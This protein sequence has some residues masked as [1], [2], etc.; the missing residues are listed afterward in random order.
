MKWTQI[1][2]TVPSE[3][4]DEAVAVMTMYDTGVMTEDYRDILTDLRTIY[5]DLIDEKILNADKSIAS[6]SIFIPEVK[7]PDDY[8]SSIKQR[9]VELNIK[10]DIS[11]IIIDEEDWANSW[12]KYYK[13]VK[14]SKRLV[15][16]PGWID[17]TPEPNERIIKMDPGMAFGIGTHE[18]TRLC[19]SLI[20]KFISPGDYML[21][22]GS[23]SGVLAICASKLGADY[24]LACDIDEV[25][26]RTE[27]ENAFSNGCGNIECIKS[28]LLADVKLKDGRP[29]DIVTANIIAEIVLRLSPDIGR[30]MRKDGV[31]IVSGIVDSKEQEIIE[32]LTQN[33]FSHVETRHENGWCGIVF[34]RV[35]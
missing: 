18:T 27:K 1:R 32:D 10:A 5:G 22:V 17:Y 24:C 11:C 25:A 30:Y 2:V 28:D 8:V 15:A 21:D 12:K 13:P 6:A 4:I 23:G 26:V 3:K 9:M 35:E 14:M 20:D 7:K 33:G 16:V 31:L 29:F 34:K 19:A